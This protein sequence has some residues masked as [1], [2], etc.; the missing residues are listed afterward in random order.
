[1]S[2]QLAIEG[3]SPVRKTLL[4]YGRQTLDEEDIQAVVGVLRSSWLTT[5][6]AVGEFERSFAERVGA[7]EAVAIS[8]GTAA[9]HAAM[10]ALGIG[11][12]DEVIVPAMTFAASTIVSSSREVPLSL[13]TWTPRVSSSTPFWSNRRSPREPKRSSLWIMRDN[14]VITT[15]W[16]HL[17]VATVWH[18]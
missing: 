8:N 1:M 11:P 10:Y 14:H 5:G 4:P 9:L 17:R 18:W 6:P 16:R 7:K 13:P 15:H 12:G 3:G 2:H